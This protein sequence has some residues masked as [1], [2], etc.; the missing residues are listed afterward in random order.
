LTV[1]PAEADALAIANEARAP[2]LV[3]HIPE[4]LLPAFTV[5]VDAP[6]DESSHFLIRENHVVSFI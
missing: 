1:A 2:T 3:S 6:S 4:R 5:I